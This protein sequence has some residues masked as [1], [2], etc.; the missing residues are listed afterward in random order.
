MAGQTTGLQKTYICESTNIAP[1]TAVTFGA[2]DGSCV[3][4]N[5]DNLIPLGVVT[6]DAKLVNAP[7]AGGVQTGRN[8]AVQI[9]G[10]AEIIAGDD[11]AYGDRVIIGANG[12]AL[13]MPAT[14]GTYNV[15]GFAEAG[16]ESG[17]II[18]VKLA[19]HVY[20]NA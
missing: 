4:P 18:P 10:I 2:S 1:Y 16:G 5:A 20:V 11:I 15:I 14:E 9:S 3:I 13:P 7:S 6:N 17:D 19:Y 8:V 12:V